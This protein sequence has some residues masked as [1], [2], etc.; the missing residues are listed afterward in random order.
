MGQKDYRVG[1]PLD[2][3]L[4]RSGKAPVVLTAGYPRCAVRGRVVRVITEAILTKGGPSSAGHFR[5]SPT[6]CLDPTRQTSLL[7]S[8]VPLACPSECE[9]ARN[10]EVQ[11]ERRGTQ[12]S[13]FD[14]GFRPFFIGNQ[15]LRHGSR[16]RLKS[17]RSPD[18]SRSRPPE[19]ALNRT[20][21]ARP[22]HQLG[23]DPSFVRREVV[24]STCP[25]TRRIPS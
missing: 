7:S 1:L 11:R 21:I 6:R 14:K 2:P 18:R 19:S 9:T 13:A 22:G 15:P 17:V 16:S 23:G 3:C 5:Q 4:R 20:H 24:V 25:T 10:S 8:F 12:I